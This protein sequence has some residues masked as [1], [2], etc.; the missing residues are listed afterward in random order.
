MTAQRRHA[1]HRPWPGRFY[2]LH[3]AARDQWRWL[4]STNLAHPL[5]NPTALTNFL[6]IFL[7][8]SIPFALTYTFGKMV[9]SI[10]HG[11]A[12]LAAMVLIF[13]SGSAL[14]ATPSTQSNPAVAAAGVTSQ[15]TGNMEGKEVRS[16]TRAAALFDVSLT[17]T[18]DGLA[19]VR[20]IRT[21]QSAVSAC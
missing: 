12:L 5:E 20:T 11:A 3:H 7:T 9:G 18:S 1:D 8:L 2:V 16:A 17:Q 4:P 14:R 13:G 10:R 15:P 19:M 21:T 6:S